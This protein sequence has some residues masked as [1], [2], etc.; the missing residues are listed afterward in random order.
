MDGGTEDMW[1]VLLDQ[2]SATAWQWDRLSLR[3]AGPY[4]KPEYD[5]M[6][7]TLAAG[8]HTLRL[9]SREAYTELDKIL[10]TND[11]AYLPQGM[12]H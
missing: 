1:D 9:R 7:F 12:G 2:Y 10:I 6:V 8:R 11:L 5:P 3:G 4:D